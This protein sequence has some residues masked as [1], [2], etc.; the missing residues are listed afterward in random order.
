MRSPMV[1]ALNGPFSFGSLTT[2]LH[3]TGF[4]AAAALYSDPEPSK[5]QEVDVSRATLI[6]H[7][8]DGR[9][10]ECGQQIRLLCQLYVS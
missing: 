3:P 4:Y 2:K 9:Y 1:W 10:V 8:S 5:S 7:I 6:T